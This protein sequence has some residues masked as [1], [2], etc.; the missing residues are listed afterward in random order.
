MYSEA[1]QQSRCNSDKGF[2]MIVFNNKQYAKNEAEFTDSLF[3]SGGTCNGFYK[4]TKNGYRLFNIQNELIAF[5][6]CA[7]EP[8]LMTATYKLLNNKNKIWYSYTDT[9]TEKYL[10]ITDLKNDFEAVANFVKNNWD[11]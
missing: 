7:K 1:I 3:T 6:R 11:N 8:M 2:K 10:G 5:V 4:R 9:Q